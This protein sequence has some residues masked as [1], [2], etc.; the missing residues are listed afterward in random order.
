MPGCHGLAVGNWSEATNGVLGLYS[1]S[2]DG[3]SRQPKGTLGSYGM[4]SRGYREF[5]VVVLA[6]VGWG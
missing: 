6:G 1:G 5:T 3:L 2:N 4:L